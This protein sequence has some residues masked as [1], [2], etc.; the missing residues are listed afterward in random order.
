VAAAR[1]LKQVERQLKEIATAEA[2]ALTAACPPC[3]SSGPSARR[4]DRPRYHRPAAERD[5]TDKKR[6]TDSSSYRP[7]PSASWIATAVQRMREAALDLPSASAVETDRLNRE[8]LDAEAAIATAKATAA[9][10]TKFFSPPLFTAA[11]VPPPA[12]EHGLASDTSSATGVATSRVPPDAPSLDDRE[13]PAT[14]RSKRTSSCPS[15]PAG[16][17]V[18]DLYSTFKSQPDHMATDNVEQTGDCTAKKHSLYSTT[19]GASSSH[20]STLSRSVRPRNNSPARASFTS[21]NP[22]TV[23]PSR[24]LAHTSSAAKAKPGACPTP[25]DK[26]LSKD[27]QS[28]LR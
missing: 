23:Q 16:V 24:G 18:N 11:L 17:G 27:I 9:E 22:T 7:M 2:A 26:K 28:L 6:K 1:E 4:Q 13:A 3:V 10:L 12:H 5:T 25:L 19:G 15:E 20:Q 21:T 8:R 14:K